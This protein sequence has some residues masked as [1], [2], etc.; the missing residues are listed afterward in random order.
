[1][2]SQ[3]WFHLKTHMSHLFIDLQSVWVS[4]FD[5]KK[6]YFAR[7]LLDNNYLVSGT[8]GWT[9]TDPESIISGNR[10]ILFESPEITNDRGKAE[11]QVAETVIIN[12]R[13]VKI[14]ELSTAKPNKLLFSVGLEYQ[15]DLDKNNISDNLQQEFNDNKNLLSQNV[16]VSIEEKYSK[17]LITNKDNKKTYSVKKERD[18]LNIYQNNKG[19]I[20]SWLKKIMRRNRKQK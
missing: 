3:E 9:Q 5:K 7:A 20:F 13:N 17:W 2:L 18:K 6:V 15:T 19:G 16:T 8:T 14:L 12:M 11:E 1:M 4:A 10:D